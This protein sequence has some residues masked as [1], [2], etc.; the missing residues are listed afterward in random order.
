MLKKLVSESFRLIESG[1]T[2]LQAVSGQ[3]PP[4]REK[5]LPATGQLYRVVYIVV[6]FSSPLLDRRYPGDPKVS[7]GIVGLVARLTAGAMLVLALTAQ[8]PTLEHWIRY[9]KR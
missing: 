8:D 9:S 1:T 5:G 3:S 6:G 2:S 7:E 4:H